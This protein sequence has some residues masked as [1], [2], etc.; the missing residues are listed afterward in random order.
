MPLRLNEK[1]KLALVTAGEAELAATMLA[2]ARVRAQAFVV[3]VTPVTMTKDTTKPAVAKASLIG[4]Y[5]N[6]PFDAAPMPSPPHPFL[7][8]HTILDNTRK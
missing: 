4:P 6:P 7:Y 3:V 8:R 5:S 1:L 2:R